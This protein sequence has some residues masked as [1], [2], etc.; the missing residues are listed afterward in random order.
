MDSSAIG[1][2]RNSNEKELSIY[3]DDRQ[4]SVP[5]DARIA[6]RYQHNDE[7]LNVHIKFIIMILCL[8]KKFLHGYTAQ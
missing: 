4:S 7:K 6:R 3:H 5:S 2:A 8:I 1:E